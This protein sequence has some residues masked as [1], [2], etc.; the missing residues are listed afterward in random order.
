[1]TMLSLLGL[2]HRLLLFNMAK[3]FIWMN[4]KKLIKELKIVYMINI[5][6]NINK[7]F[8]EQVDR[9]MKTKF[10]SSTQPHIR[11][12][13]SKNKTRV[14]SLIILYETRSENIYFRVLSSVI[15]TVI[16]NYVYIDYLAC[17]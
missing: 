1:M 14:L 13:L 4:E 5:N 15:Y 8:R 17:Q 3:R 6:F 7:V 2:N 16:E 10:G 11:S 12:I 9:Y